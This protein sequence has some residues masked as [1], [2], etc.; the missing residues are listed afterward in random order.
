MALLVAV[1][2]PVAALVALGAVQVQ[3]V[4]TDRSRT[5]DV[6]DA[7][8]LWGAQQLTITP[9]GSAER[10][11][12]FADAQLTAVRANSTV[13]VAAEVIGLNRMKVTIDTHRPSFFLNLMPMGGFFTHVESVAEGLTQTPLCVLIIGPN[14][15][16]DLKMTQSSK[17]QGPGCLMHSNHAVQAGASALVRANTVAASTSASGPIQ[18]SASVGAPPI[19]DPFASIG[20]NFPTPCLATLP[21]TYYTSDGTLAPGVH[22]FHIDVKNGKKLTL[23]AGTH[24][25]C[26]DLL[27][28][29]NAILDGLAG[30]TM[31]FS[32]NSILDTK[33][34]SVINLKGSKTGAHA[35]FVIVTERA[36]TMDLF[37]D[38]DP[39]SNITGVIYVP[40]AKVALDG[41]VQAGTTSAWTVLAAKALEGRGA[42]D[43][44]I[45][46]DYRGSD[47]PVPTGVGNKTGTTHLE[48]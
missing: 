35:G 9:S 46:V 40:T 2:F 26:G 39:I 19:P 4:Y 22:Q 7:A 20:F 48:Q 36:R 21:W 16:D 12:A 29:S 14:T 37:I 3:A 43:L 13:T 44:L 31:V 1:A 27:F 41:E 8:A 45:D 11:K 5:Q 42:S 10:T 6:A 24:Y 28:K 30:V 17:L 32:R 47:V 25:F 15:G 18:P 23:Q 38:T 34:A 33:D